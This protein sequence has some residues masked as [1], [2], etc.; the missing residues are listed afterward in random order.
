[1][2]EDFSAINRALNIDG[3]Y[4]IE[5]SYD[6]CIPYP[7]VLE[8]ERKERA[9]KLYETVKRQRLQIAIEKYGIKDYI[10]KPELRIIEHTP[11]SR[12]NWAQKHKKKD[13]PKDRPVRIINREDLGYMKPGLIDK[14]NQ[15]NFIF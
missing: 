4:I 5:V 6:N 13:T 7:N 10:K 1:M 8:I 3:D 11:R 2:K 14:V 9:N 12:Y 15:T